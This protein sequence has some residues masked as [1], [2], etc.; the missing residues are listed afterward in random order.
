MTVRRVSPWIILAWLLGMFAFLSVIA[1]TI[2]VTAQPKVFEVEGTGAIRNQDEAAAR[3]EALRDA[4]RRALEAAGVRVSSLTEVRNF[5]VFY[6]Y[7]LTRADGYIRRWQIL[8]ERRDGALYRI[9]VRAEVSVGNIQGDLEA[10]DLLIEMMGN[11]AVMVLL[12]SD[13]WYPFGDLMETEL[14]GRLADAGYHVVDAP[15]FDR[16]RREDVVRQLFLSGDRQAAIT[17]GVRTGADLFIIGRLDIQDLG[18]T[19]FGSVWLRSASAVVS[20]KVVAASTGQTLSA[21]TEQAASADVTWDSAGA[22]AARKLGRTIGSR[23][24]WDIPR[25]FGPVLGQGRTLQLIVTGVNYDLLTRLVAVLKV[26]RGVEGRVYVRSFEGTVAV[27]DL[28]STMP[29]EAL[30]ARLRDERTLRIVVVSVGAVRAEIRI[31]P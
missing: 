28:K 30:L 29:I 20:F 14:G 4:Y 24:A 23:L 17:L 13:R 8:S 5:Q 11:P 10:L 9:R 15:Q 27:L 1:V 2:P 21:G 22:E 25:R 6:D 16:V 19:S 18:G 26:L 31:L 12:T 3:D 7:I